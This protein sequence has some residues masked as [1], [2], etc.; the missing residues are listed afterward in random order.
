MLSKMEKRRQLQ[1]FVAK[2]A[3]DGAQV[4]KLLGLPSVRYPFHSC[5]PKSTLPVIKAALKSGFEEGSGCEVAVCWGLLIV[6]LNEFDELAGLKDTASQPDKSTLF[7]KLQALF[8]QLQTHQ[9]WPSL[10]WEKTNIL[11]GFSGNL[12]P[13]A[14]TAGVGEYA[15][16]ESIRAQLC[17]IMGVK[18]DR[19]VYANRTLKPR[20]VG[21]ST[22]PPKETVRGILEDYVEDTL[23]PSLEAGVQNSF[24]AGLV[25]AFTAAFYDGI[26]AHCCCGG[27]DVRSILNRFEDIEQD[28]STELI[29]QHLR[30]GDRVTVTIAGRRVLIG[31]PLGTATF[32]LEKTFAS[33]QEI[34]RSIFPPTEEACSLPLREAWKAF[35]MLTGLV[36]GQG[37]ELDV[38]HVQSSVARP[39]KTTGFCVVAALGKQA[40]GMAEGKKKKQ[41]GR[42]VLWIHRS[43]KGQ[44]E[45]E[46]RRERTHGTLDDEFMR[47]GKP[48]L[49]E[50]KNAKR[51]KVDA[52]TKQVVAAFKKSGR[53][54]VCDDIH[55][56]WE[57]TE[58]SLR[59]EGRA[60]Q[61]AP[62]ASAS[63]GAPPAACESRKNNVNLDV[64]GVRRTE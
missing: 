1:S 38:S 61:P 25:F 9:L 43:K 14:G 31:H 8:E 13:E 6:H 22:P 60:A 24:T 36:E 44:V 27:Y 11:V 30:R 45:M 50:G 42:D 52:F 51:D 16:E 2:Y 64:R 29:G 56:Q 21:L 49:L 57:L 17:S 63:A 47:K 23:R 12:V 3:G 37:R 62:S 41:K 5:T 35:D 46:M 40:M 48:L 54:I 59:E 19:H 26:V 20:E 39:F 10:E 4:A 18:Y 7:A 58:A 34:V 53:C 55:D 15:E 28:I 33:R 32:P